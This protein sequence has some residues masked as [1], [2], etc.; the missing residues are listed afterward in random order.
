[1]PRRS[2]LLVG[3][4][5]VTMHMAVEA[6]TIVILQ[7]DGQIIIAADSKRRYEQG[8]HTLLEATACKILVVR[9]VVFAA[10]GLT[11]LAGADGTSIFD[12]RALASQTLNQAGRLTE[13]VRR[14]DQALARELTRVRDVFNA[15]HTTALFLEVVLAGLKNG[16]P[17]L[18]IRRFEIAAGVDGR[19]AA[20]RIDSR[21]CDECRNLIEVFGHDDGIFDLLEP[22][23]AG[24][25]RR[26]ER[27]VETAR[28]FI[29]TE[30][31]QTPDW[32]GPPIDVLHLDRWGIHWDERKPECGGGR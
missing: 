3:V 27:T 29:R 32:V 2:S 14:F 18:F 6:T 22:K 20:R 1:M 25:I 24:E 28:T 17:A 7:S 10:S 12:V 4:L 9:D 11:A 31:A 16:R 5:L 23:T 13:R 19:L 30:I 15:R 8:G 26:M 21:S